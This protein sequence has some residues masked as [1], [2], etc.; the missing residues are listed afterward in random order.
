MYRVR[1]TLV[2]NKLD[3]SECC[4]MNLLKLRGVEVEDRRGMRKSHA[5]LLGLLT[6]GNV[7]PSSASGCKTLETDTSN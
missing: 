4:I 1:T 7:R 5:E 6:G 3:E 2:H